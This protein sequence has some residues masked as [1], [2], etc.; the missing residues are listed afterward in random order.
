MAKT[1]LFIENEEVELTEDIQFA[2]T[3]QFVDIE[4]PT[5]IIS[6]WSKTINIPFT[7][8]NNKLF[9]D[10][11]KEDRV[12][13][14]STNNDTTGIFFDPYKKLNFYLTNGDNIIMTGYLKTNSVEKTS[15]G[16]FYQVTLNGEIGKVF[17][18]LKNI[19]VI[20][21]IGN[22]KYYIGDILKNVEINKDIVYKSWNNTPR[23][24]I[25]IEYA[26]IN[27]IIGFAPTNTMKIEGFDNTSI[28]V[29]RSNLTKKIPLSDYRVTCSDGIQRSIKD[30]YSR[31]GFNIDS[32]IGNG[33][34]QQQMNQFRSYLCTPYIYV[35]RLFEILNKKC[36]E[37][38]GYNVEIDKEWCFK[39]P[40]YNDMV[41]ML[42]NF[43]Q[44]DEVGYYGSAKLP[45]IETLERIGFNTNNSIRFSSK[46]EPQ[47]QDIIQ[48][49][50]GTLTRGYATYFKIPENKTLTI[51]CN[52]PV[53]LFI[54]PDAT[55]TNDMMFNLS[56]DTG[57]VIDVKFIGENGHTEQYQIYLLA[58]DTTLSVPKNPNIKVIFINDYSVRPYISNGGWAFELPIYY[59]AS[60]KVFGN[61]VDV[62]LNPHFIGYY[63]YPIRDTTNDESFAYN[64]QPYIKQVTFNSD[65]KLYNLITDSNRSNTIFNLESIWDSSKQFFDCILNYTKMFR[66]IWEIDYVEKKIKII[67]A[68]KYFKNSFE[69]I[70]DISDKVDFNKPFNI[71]PLFIKDK[72]L[73]LNYTVDNNKLNNIYTDDLSLNYGEKLLTT[74]YEYNNNTKKAFGN[75]N[76]AIEEQRNDILWKDIKDFAMKET[77][78]GIQSTVRG[79]RAGNIL[80]NQ[81]DKDNKVYNLFG[82]FIMYLGNMTSEDDIIISDDSITELATAEYCFIDY[83]EMPVSQSV[84]IISKKYPI[85]SNFYDMEHTDESGVSKHTACTATFSIPGKVFINLPNARD[86]YKSMYELL[87]ESYI[88]GEL[89]NKNTK[90]ISCYINLNIADYIHLQK[91][92]FVIYNGLLYILN[93]IENYSITDRS[94]KCQLISVNN[95][96]NYIKDNFLKWI[97]NDEGLAYY[98]DD[99][100]REGNKTYRF[101]YEKSN[102][103]ELKAQTVLDG[104]IYDLTINRVGNT[105]YWDV[106]IPNYTHSI[107]VEIYY[108]FLDTIWYTLD[109]STFLY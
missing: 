68:Y 51:A 34:S 79:D 7:Q 32:L 14:S 75:I 22:E 90:E 48:F 36:Y 76:I 27:D 103:H 67:P 25:P 15:G 60:R 47:G 58:V 61:S 91:N 4:D 17:Q 86:L 82:S 39:N 78:P 74:N 56:Q 83:D 59:T 50:E 80:L 69:N 5:T 33:L 18:E 57:V 85:L 62:K 31:Q 44:T 49:G 84:S 105:N 100:K 106:F 35:S 40:Y 109:T 77:M 21:N 30:A 11:Y 98:L 97:R 87:W 53:R 43:K 108:T 13:V 63:D 45:Q 52:L 64:G 28:I 99:D 54:D 12:V 42:K 41:M 20:N 9:G 88:S 37:L 89:L 94:T 23:L 66:L 46:I 8:S 96:N 81:I 107:D 38:T 16:G 92:K 102:E 72:N 93:K 2:L 70:I 6:S 3:T 10:L 73:L 55:L 65:L 19:S 104:Q 95:P 101:Y 1:R 71:N 24:N 26:D 29:S